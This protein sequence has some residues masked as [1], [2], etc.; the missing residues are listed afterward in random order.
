MLSLDHFPRTWF[1]SGGGWKNKLIFSIVREKLTNLIGESC[2][3]EQTDSLGW[4]SQTLES[5]MMAY[6]AIRCL[7]KK[8]FSYPGTTGVNSP[9]LGGVIYYC[10]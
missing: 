2:L 1:V 7:D 8:P 6:L 3:L 5:N 4:G 9:S 10:R